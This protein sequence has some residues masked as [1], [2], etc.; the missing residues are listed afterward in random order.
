MRFQ[1]AEISHRRVA[2]A[3]QQR[4][5]GELDMWQLAPLPSVALMAST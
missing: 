3:R 2:D 4:A 5:H 1:A